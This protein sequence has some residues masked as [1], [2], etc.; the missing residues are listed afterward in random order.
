MHEKTLYLCNHCDFVSTDKDAVIAHECQKHFGITVEERST[1]IKLLKKA[2]HAGK[3]VSVCKNRETD[4]KFDDACRAL[5]DFE[6][7]HHL[8]GLR[9]FR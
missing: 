5:A 1:W 6:V 3:A 2:E 9:P 8:E 7:E 4:Q